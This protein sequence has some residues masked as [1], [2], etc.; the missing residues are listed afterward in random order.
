M[1]E[2]RTTTPT[3]RGCIKATRNPWKVKHKGRDGSIRMSLRRPSDQEREKNRLREKRRR[4]VTAKIFACLKKHGNYNLP[5]HADQNDVLF[6]LCDEAGWHVDQDGVISRK[7]KKVDNDGS[8]IPATITTNC[9]RYSQL[10]F[11]QNISTTTT[12]EESSAHGLD[13]TL[14]LGRF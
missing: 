5:K 8:T 4:M 3:M 14:T 10:P 1:E 11:L 13:L 9:H 12:E 6:A 7:E 2:E